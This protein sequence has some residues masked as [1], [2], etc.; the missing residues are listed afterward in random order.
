[1]I[2]A[3]LGRDDG[4]ERHRTWKTSPEIGMQ[5]FRKTGATEPD[6]KRGNRSSRQHRILT[7]QTSNATIFSQFFHNLISGG[8]G[9]NAPA[10]R[11]APAKLPASAKRQA[12]RS[13][14][15]GGQ[16]R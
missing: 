5:L 16:R 12:G 1:M 10:C 9:A 13:P 14:R 2:A 4:R 8:T 11:F 3:G 7:D 6:L 15:V